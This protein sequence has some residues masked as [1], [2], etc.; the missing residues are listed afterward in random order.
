MINIPSHIRNSKKLYENDDIYYYYFISCTPPCKSCDCDEEGFFL[1]F[2]LYMGL[3]RRNNEKWINL[4]AHKGEYPEEHI[5]TSNKCKAIIIP[6]SPCHIYQNEPHVLKMLKWL[7]EFYTNPRYNHIKLLGICFGHQIFSHATGGEVIC[8]RERK[9]VFVIESLN[10]LPKFW[11]LGF[12]KN[13]KV[14]PVKNMNVMQVHLDEVVT[15]PEFMKKFSFSESCPCEILVSDDERVFTLQGHPEYTPE[16][17][18]FRTLNNFVSPKS[19]NLSDDE[20]EDVL[21]NFLAATKIK[22]E[23]NVNIRSICFSFLKSK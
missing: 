1:L 3:F 2:P 13:S 17:Y 15:I 23:V 10:F 18:L 5:L 14:I 19:K 21:N 12:V 16:F 20:F 7:K 22:G 9:C 11:E 8:R 6:G 4:H